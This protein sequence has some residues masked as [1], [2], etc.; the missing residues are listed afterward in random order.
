M[1]PELAQTLEARDFVDPDSARRA[2]QH[3][4][5]CYK[6]GQN[7]LLIISTNQ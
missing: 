5:L 4:W 1:T 6:I 3:N 7:H 2:L